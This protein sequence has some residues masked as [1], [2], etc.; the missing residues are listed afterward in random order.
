[1]KES[2]HMFK[3]VLAILLSV[4]ILAS[5]FAFFPVSAVTGEQAAQIA[6]ADFL[7]S[8]GDDREIS[9]GAPVPLYN[10]KDS[11]IA[12][13]IFISSAD[14]Y[15][16]FPIIIGHSFSATFEGVS[17]IVSV[18]GVILSHWISYDG[19]VISPDRGGR[20]YYCSYYKTFWKMSA[21]GKIT[22]EY[23]T[24]YSR[25]KMNDIFLKA[26]AAEKADAE[27]L[28]IEEM[29]EKTGSVQDFLVNGKKLG[30][31]RIVG[32]I[33]ALLKR[34]FGYVI[35][36]RITFPADWDKASADTEVEKA[37]N[38]YCETNNL[39]VKEVYRADKDYFVPNKQRYFSDG[40]FIG[41][42]VCGVASWEMLLGGY[43]DMGVLSE[44][45]DDITMYREIM[46]IMDDI[47]G[48]L[49]PKIQKI[50]G[51]YY[52]FIEEYV[53][54]VLSN[55]AGMHIDEDFFFNSY[56]VLGTLDVGIAM[57]LQQ[58]GYT[59]YAKRVLSN[60][61]VGIPVLSPV[62]RAIF[63][64]DIKN[65]VSGWLYDKTDGKLVL[66]TGLGSTAY[67]TVLRSLE[68]GEPAAIGCWMSLLGDDDLTNHYFVAVSLF[69]VKGEL[70]L[71]DSRS[72]PV[73]RNLIEIYD[74]WD[75][76]SV[77]LV[78]FDALF[79]TTLSDANSLALLW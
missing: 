68:R 51:K 69:K 45:P 7:V 77:E 52:P 65:T 5:C 20:L 19:S 55:V 75:N 32:Y 30:I 38:E 31:K 44:L 15:L 10:E 21:D 26:S 57:Y 43:R 79:L 27:R 23:G 73:E 53:N 2:D 56:E 50:I 9:V 37:L 39:T 62:N 29:V 33:V 48:E 63:M 12:Y 14:G 25:E 67:D 64:R 6:Q 36:G 47:T 40:A 1:M 66:P 42:G 41:D 24:V 3:K 49:V 78:D 11:V 18:D 76:K 4:C 59:E 60:I 13:L 72:I 8:F 70:K 22:D 61:T 71:S 35:D 17:Y 58:Y 16:S 34:F 74:T 28:E 46:A 54:P